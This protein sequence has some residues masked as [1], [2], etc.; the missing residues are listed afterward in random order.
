MGRA[1]ERQPLCPKR[2]KSLLGINGGDENENVD[3]F[4][5]KFN[6]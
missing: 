4:L 1:G 5:K 3:V 6:K 2:D